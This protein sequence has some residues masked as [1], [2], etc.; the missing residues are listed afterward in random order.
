MAIVPAKGLLWM[1]GLFYS[2]N[3]STKKEEES[4]QLAELQHS[5]KLEDIV[6]TLVPIILGTNNP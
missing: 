5:P 6:P 3:K 4:K 1:L 2:N